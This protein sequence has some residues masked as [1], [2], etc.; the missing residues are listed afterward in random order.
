MV[1]NYILLHIKLQ[2][3]LVNIKRYIPHIYIY[4]YLF[5]YDTA[6]LLPRFPLNSL[7]VYI[8]YIHGLFIY[9]HGYRVE[10]HPIDEFDWL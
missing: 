3:K 8:V 1:H 5:I 2:Y 9:L 6:I 7:A 10:P 4:I